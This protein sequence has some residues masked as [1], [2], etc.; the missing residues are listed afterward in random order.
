[1]EESEKKLE[2][3]VT[4]LKEI[5]TFLLFLVVVFGSTTALLA[6]ELSE[7]SGYDI[8]DSVSSGF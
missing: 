4:N 8:C 3:K 1:M 6:I 2:L 7:R 5:V